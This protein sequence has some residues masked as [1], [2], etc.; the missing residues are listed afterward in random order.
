MYRREI[1][2]PSADPKRL[3]HRFLIAI[4]L[5]EFRPSPSKQSHL[6]FSNRE[7][8]AVFHFKTLLTI[9]RPTKSPGFNPTIDTERGFH[10]K[11][12]RRFSPLIRPFHP[13]AELKALPREPQITSY[14]SRILICRW[15][16]S[17]NA[18]FGRY[19]ESRAAILEAGANERRKQRM[20]CEGFR[21]ELRME[22]A[23]DKPGMVG[24][25]DDLNIYAV[26][27]AARDSE[28]GAGERRLVLAIEFV[29]MAM[30]LG[31]FQRAIRF[32][33]KRAGL[34]FAR[35]RAQAH[36]AAHFVHAQQFAQFVNHAIR[37]RRIELRAVRI[38]DSRNLPR[39]FDRRALH[40]QA[41]PEERDLF[42]PRVGNRVN[43][44]GNAALAEAAGNQ[45]AIGVAQKFVG[46]C[47]RI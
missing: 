44:S 6:T 4:P 17:R 1:T 13:R 42:L 39:I 40:A 47:D 27:C 33:G 11:V 30:A 29:A 10:R 23:A 5:L 21:L 12:A 20:W 32:I 36:R 14:K 24:H 2:T 35:P 19:A 45:D 22:L 41:N 37:R 8:I 3:T 34:K 31:N 43:H 18:L 15:I 25:F 28:S 16:C 38:F 46:R 26:R 9:A 7:Y